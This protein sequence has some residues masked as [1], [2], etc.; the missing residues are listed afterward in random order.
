MWLTYLLSITVPFCGSSLEPQ[1]PPSGFWFTSKCSAV[2]PTPNMCSSSQISGC[3]ASSSFILLKT[4]LQK[5]LSVS[6]S[7]HFLL[8]S[9]SFLVI[10]GSFIVLLFGHQIIPESLLPRLS[11]CSL[12]II[13]NL[14]LTR[15]PWGTWVA[16]LVKCLAV[17][18]SSGCDL[19]VQG[20]L[21]Q[22]L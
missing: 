17:G 7:F 19:R 9:S 1:V 8:F 13:L 16:Q 6:P 5:V 18:F 22:S 20:P 3:F 21:I 4:Q 15:R 2:A 12:H 14:I 10:P 11:F